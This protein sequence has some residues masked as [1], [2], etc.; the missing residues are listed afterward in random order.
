MLRNALS[1]HVV[2]TG[3]SNPSSQ[4]KTILKMTTLILIEKFE[5]R[6]RSMRRIPNRRNYIL[7]SHH[8]NLTT[9]ITCNLCSFDLLCF[10]VF[11]SHPAIVLFASSWVVAALVYGAFD[12]QV[13][14]DP[15]EMW[16]SPQ[17]RSRLEK[18][19]FDS[20]FEPFYRT[21]QVFV[22]AVGIQKVSMRV[23]Q[24]KPVQGLLWAV[25]IDVEAAETL[26]HGL[27]SW[28]RSGTGA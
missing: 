13:T 18:E 4:K 28:A 2:K 5:N 8:P 23:V 1:N 24:M 9:R 26:T 20:R 10:A 17:S 15:V 12:L 21:E 7:N 14:T 19:Y 22:K 16:A 6:Q 27:I 11:A 25:L 3:F